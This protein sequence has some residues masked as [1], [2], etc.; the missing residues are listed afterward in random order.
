MPKKNVAGS[1]L[2][3]GMNVDTILFTSMRENV[4][5]TVA[6][7]LSGGRLRFWINLDSRQFFFMFCIYCYCNL[8]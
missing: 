3:P 7:V 6:R 2:M 8:L 5:R 4:V 1:G